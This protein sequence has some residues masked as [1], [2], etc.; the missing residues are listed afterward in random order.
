MNHRKRSLQK[1]DARRR[2]ELI[3]YDVIIKHL[4]EGPLASAV[5]GSGNRQH[6]GLSTDLALFD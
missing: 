2:Y 5:E 1:K 4:A 6:H 3:Y